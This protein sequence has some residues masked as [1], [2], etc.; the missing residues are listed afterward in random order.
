M[1]VKFL[2]V[3]AVC[4]AVFALPA[5]VNY[6]E[7]MASILHDFSS[8]NYLERMGSMNQIN[9]LIV[10]TTNGDELVECRLLKSAVLL[11]R[12]ETEHDTLARVE[13][14]NLLW[15][16][17]REYANRPKDWRFFGARLVLMQSL[18]LGE[19]YAKIYSIA[20]NTIPIAPTSGLERSTNVWSA[21]FGPEIPDVISL[22]DAFRFNA[23]DAL[24]SVDKAADVNALTNGL[25]S[26]M[27]IRL[28]GIHED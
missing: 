8:T 24:L 28:V 13:A 9:A 4:C 17:E 7:Q 2:S 23:A 15:A 14:T 12:A 16:I 25:P 20:T 5:E 21:L 6:H 10:A 3:L 26:E 1:K 22:R 11:E 18:A 19:E 27:T